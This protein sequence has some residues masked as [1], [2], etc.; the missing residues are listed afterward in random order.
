[1]NFVRYDP[2]TGIVVSSGQMEES[3]LDALIVQGDNILKTEDYYSLDNIVN[4]KTFQINRKLSPLPTE[5]L[6]R[7]ILYE[8][9]NTDYTQLP[10]VIDR[11]PADEQAWW[12]EYRQMLRTASKLDSFEGVM[13]ALPRFNPKHVDNFE[14]YRRLLPPP[15][16]K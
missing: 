8:L 10:D 11:T 5:E 15:P 3:H 13:A 12:R 2:S 4:L 9:Q 14:A 6:K 7:A 1:M 16:P